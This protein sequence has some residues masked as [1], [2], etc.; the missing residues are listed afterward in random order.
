METIRPR[1]VDIE[2]ERRALLDVLVDWKWD[3]LPA[4]SVPGKEVLETKILLSD[5]IFAV[6]KPGHSLARVWWALLELVDSKVAD[7]WVRPSS[8]L[9][10]L[11]EGEPPTHYLNLDRG[12]NCVFL[13]TTPERINV[14]IRIIY[15]GSLCSLPPPGVEPQI[16]VSRPKWDKVAR[17]LTFGNILCRHYKRFPT[18]QSQVLNQFEE[19]GWPES[20]QVSSYQITK[21]TIVELN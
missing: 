8:M 12:D 5:L 2:S 19:E 4:R 10:N 1:P 20:I 11:P 13:V 16:S 6:S 7:L 9:E 15:R 17:N 14:Y 21:H 3:S 18:V